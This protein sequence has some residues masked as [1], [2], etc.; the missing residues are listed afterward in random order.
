M[1]GRIKED[2]INEI[3]EKVDLV[4]IVSGYVSLKKAGRLFKGLCPF[5]KE[6]TPSFMVDPGKQLYHCFGCGEGGNVYNFLMKIE[7]IDFPEAVQLLAE[8]LNFTLCYEQPTDSKA[9]SRRERMYHINELAQKFY[10][11]IL[12]KTKEGEKARSYLKKRGYD[13]NICRVFNLGFAPADGKSLLKF[14]IKKGYDTKELL[15]VGLIIEGRK[16]IHDLFRNRI[17]FSISDLRGKSIAFGGRIIGDGLP[18]YINTPETPIFHKSSTLYNQALAK[19]EIVRSGYALVVEGYT[20]VISLF[21]AGIKSVVA[22][23]GTAFTSD[24]LYLLSRFTDKVILL[25]DADK[26]GNAAAERGLGLLSQS[27]V[28]VFIASLPAGKDPADF[29]ASEGAD[30]FRSRI[31]NAVSLVEFCINQVLLKHKLGDSLER[32]KAV[33]EAVD[34]IALLDSAVLR[35]DFLKK[36]GDKLSISYDSILTEMKK[37][38]RQKVKGKNSSTKVLLDAQ[39][40][41]EREILKLILQHP[42]K[43]KACLT[44]IE[45]ECFVDSANRDLFLFFLGRLG[46]NLSPA[47]IISLISEKELVNLATSLLLESIN[48]DADN[49]DKYFLDILNRLKDFSLGRQI[50]TLRN[51]LKE[52]DASSNQAD[53]DVIFKKLIELENKKRELRQK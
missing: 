36:L 8:N 44:E 25:F 3:R 31:D 52:A 22:T 28:D 27:K 20:D 53:V 42:D 4:E 38:K 23:L 10:S 13:E 50:N 40:K 35:E 37:V 17:I 41:A 12:L 5:H 24:H 14:L 11:H 49:W 9:A 47:D 46:E 21:Q 29:I 30:L 43:I 33:N 6:K 16:G 19:N 7:N 39:A 2:D 34:I 32:A 18:K 1:F 51:E 26:A 48:V 45:E 15:A